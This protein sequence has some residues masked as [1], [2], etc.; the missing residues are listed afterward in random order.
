MKELKT[1][2]IMILG[3]VLLMCY[4]INSYGLASQDTS[5]V[6]ISTVYHDVKTGVNK[7]APKIEKAIGTIAKDLKVTADQVWDILV[8][9]QQVWSIAYLIGEI[10]AI[11][12]WFHFYY[13]IRKGRESNWGSDVKPEDASYTITVWLTFIIAMTMSIISLVHFS[14]MLTGFIN[15]RFGAMKTIA[16]V[17]ENIK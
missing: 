1:Y 8:K 14:E 4:S 11:Y 7:N 17:A 12:S 10:T 16:T 2:I 3:I 15:P 9:Q 13:R 6:S 5:K